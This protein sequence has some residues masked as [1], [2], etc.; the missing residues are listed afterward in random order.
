MASA[1]FASELT[2]LLLLIAISLVAACRHFRRLLESSWWWVVK[3]PKKKVPGQA[4]HWAARQA[5]RDPCESDAPRG[6]FARTL[7]QS[8]ERGGRRPRQC[9][10]GVQ[11]SLAP[12]PT[13]QINKPLVR[14]G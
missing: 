6:K 3:W 7:Q 1:A 11:A 10:A 5:S 13:K 2:D 8:V 12:D 4:D 9:E 14:R